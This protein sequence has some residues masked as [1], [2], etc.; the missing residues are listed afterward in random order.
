MR[1]FLVL[2]LFTIFCSPF[3]F[4]TEDQAIPIA[5]NIIIDSIV[6]F[7]SEREM[8]L[9]AKQKMIKT[10][11]IALGNTPIGK[12]QFEGDGKTPEGLYFIDDKSAVS[13]YH[14]NLN[15]S[16]P[17]K[18]DLK[19][20][21]ENGKSAGDDIKIHRLPNRFDDANY[22][23]TDWTLGCIALKNS[24]IDELFAHVKIGSPIFIL[25]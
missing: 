6:V 21:T 4:C 15:V 24:E 3:G 5:K 19:Y 12:K 18:N 17:N 9:Y 23:R 25:P 1:A 10:Y 7:K 20:A 2:I 14:K 22:L 13:K 8:Q 16:Y 11:R